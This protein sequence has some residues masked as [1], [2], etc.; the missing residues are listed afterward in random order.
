MSIMKI[1]SSGKECSTSSIPDTHAC[2]G[3][4]LSRYAGDNMFYSN[5]ERDAPAVTLKR[6]ILGKHLYLEVTSIS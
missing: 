2:D 6:D 4:Y 5:C 1:V 3:P